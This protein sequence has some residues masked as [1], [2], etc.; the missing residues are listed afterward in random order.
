MG[1]ARGEL[2]EQCQPFVPPQFLVHAAYA[3]QVT[4]GHQQPWRRADAEEAR[5]MQRE[6]SPV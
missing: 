5:L 3:R 1:H 4:Q 6:M 2:T